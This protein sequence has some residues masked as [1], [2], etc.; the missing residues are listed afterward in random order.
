M[1]DATLRRLMNSGKAYDLSRA[2][3]YHKAK[4]EI[5]IRLSEPPLKITEIEILQGVLPLTDDGR[6]EI[7][8]VFEMYEQ[9]RY[10]NQLAMAQLQFATRRCDE[11]L[12]RLDMAWMFEKY[13]ELRG[14]DWKGLQIDDDFNNVASYS[15]D[16][17]ID[18][19]SE[20]VDENESDIYNMTS[21]ARW[22][23]GYIEFVELVKTVYKIP[24]VVECWTMYD[25]LPD[26]LEYYNKSRNRLLEYYKTCHNKARDKCMKAIVRHFPELRESDYTVPQK[27]IKKATQLFKNDNFNKNTAHLMLTTLCGDY[28]D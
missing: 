22:V 11:V 23:R 26:I 10:N 16:R 18:P 28:V 14:G 3:L 19:E 7:Q 15:A 20:L 21:A 25:P 24:E 5:N 12:A 4:T 9:L 8:R 1:T 6:S 13:L 17:Y 27:L 2:W